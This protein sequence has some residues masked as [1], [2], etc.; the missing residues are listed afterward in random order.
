MSQRHHCTAAALPCPESAA[1]KGRESLT[2]EDV[3]DPTPCSIRTTAEHCTVTVS[4]TDG[5][6]RRFAAFMFETETQG[7]RGQHS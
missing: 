3:L 1:Y 6:Y 4:I 2:R 5:R 7:C